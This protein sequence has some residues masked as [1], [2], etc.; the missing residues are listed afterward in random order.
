[1][2]VELRDKSF[3]AAHD[4][5]YLAWSNDSIHILPQIYYY[6]ISSM[7]TSVT[8]QCSSLMLDFDIG[9]DLAGTV[10]INC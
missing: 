1:M 4:L 6:F 9:L 2:L 8:K 3:I 7:G 5:L 10:V